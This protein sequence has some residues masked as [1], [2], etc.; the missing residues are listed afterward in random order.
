MAFLILDCFVGNE[1]YD[2]AMISLALAIP[3]FN[4]EES[5]EKTV[6]MYLDA[7]RELTSDF[8]IV[9]LDDGS[10]DRTRTIIERLA[11]QYPMIITPVYYARHEGMAK[12]FEEVQRAATKEYV[13]LLGADGQYP[14]DIIAS[15]LP[16]L[17]THDVLICKRRQKHYSFLR[18][19]V[20][21]LYRWICYLLFGIDLLDPGGTKMIRRA[22]FDELPVRSRSVF[23]QPERVI[24]AA[25]G[26]YRIGTVEVACIPRQA[27]KAKG[28]NIRLIL[29]ALRDVCVVWWE[30]R[31]TRSTPKLLRS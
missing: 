19:V 21:G 2:L 31:S 9:L 13:I 1:E 4:E 3:A 24:R 7:L 6:N 11:S 5:L 12:A 23:A 30:G 27:G 26:G 15:C 14:P 8:E 25:R 18:S 16:H 17:G 10:T 28:C 29:S 20:S 22:L